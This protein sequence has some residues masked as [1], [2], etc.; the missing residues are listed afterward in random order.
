MTKT[1]SSAHSLARCR[2]HAVMLMVSAYW[3]RISLPYSSSTLL[4]AH[5]L[6]VPVTC[7]GK[8]PVISLPSQIPLVIGFQRIMSLFFLELVVVPVFYSCHDVAS[9]SPH[10]PHDCKLQEDRNVS[11]FLFF[12]R[13]Y[14]FIFRER[15]REG[16]RKRD[17]ETSVCGCLSHAPNWGPG[18]QPRHVP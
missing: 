14:L 2:S 1:S 10:H 8:L 4:F 9:M 15:R 16:G 5:Q 17:R 18:P 6:S 3:K 11:I 12:Q 7:S 13:L